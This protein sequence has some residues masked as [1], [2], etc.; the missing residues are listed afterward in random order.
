MAVLIVVRGH[1]VKTCGARTGWSSG[2]VE[3]QNRFMLGRAGRGKEWVRYAHWV[4]ESLACAIFKDL[5]LCL[6]IRV[7]RA[8]T[9]PLWGGLGAITRDVPIWFCFGGA[10]VRWSKREATGCYTH[11]VMAGPERAELSWIGSL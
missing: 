1:V 10:L 7:F 2:R 5:T 6:L 11:T 4:V 9:S 8:T 3:P